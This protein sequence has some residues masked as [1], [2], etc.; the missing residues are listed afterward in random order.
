MAVNKK[1]EFQMLIIESEA[2]FHLQQCMQRLTEMQEVLENK[3]KIIESPFAF[4]ALESL[5][6]AF[7]VSKHQ[8]EK[9]LSKLEGVKTAIDLIKQGGDGVDE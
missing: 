7:S 6:K 9:C 4:Q 1:L 8:H 2:K 5:Y 3:E